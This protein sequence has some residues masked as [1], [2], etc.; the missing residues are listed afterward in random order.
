MTPPGVR[1]HGL[2]IGEELKEAMLVDGL[3]EG[4]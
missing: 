4:T 3:K 1:D 2:G